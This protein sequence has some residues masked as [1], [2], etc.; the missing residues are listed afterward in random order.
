MAKGGRIGQLP[1]DLIGNQGLPSR[2]VGNERLEMLLEQTRR[3]THVSS[4]SPFGSTYRRAQISPVRSA[5]AAVSLGKVRLSPCG[6]ASEQVRRTRT[7]AFQGRRRRPLGAD[8][9]LRRR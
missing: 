1:D 9:V 4:L 8:P 3:R 5:T 7:S 2:V 6:F